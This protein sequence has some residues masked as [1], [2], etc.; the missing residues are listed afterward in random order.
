MCAEADGQ[1][2][3]SWSP[4]AGTKSVERFDGRRRLT[5]PILRGE[6]GAAVKPLRRE[7]RSDFGVP[8]LACVR[9]FVLHAWQWVRRAP[10]IPC[11]MVYGLLRALAGVPGLLASVA[12]SIA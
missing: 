11:T 1:V 5:S 12:C 9:L 6:R 2:A 10:G 8:V 7:C 4:D 3:W